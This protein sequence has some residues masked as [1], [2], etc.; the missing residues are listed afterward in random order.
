[1]VDPRQLPAA[2]LTVRRARLS[3]AADADITSAVTRACCCPSSMCCCSCCRARACKVVRC[4]LM[5][6]KT[7]ASTRNRRALADA[8]A[9][10]RPPTSGGFSTV[11]S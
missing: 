8:A 3:L 10:M 5:V 11:F 6:S 1:M 9:D 2:R 7:P 4:F